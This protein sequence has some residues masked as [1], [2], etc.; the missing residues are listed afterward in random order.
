MIIYNS[1]IARLISKFIM[2]IEAITLWPFILITGPKIVDSIILRA[3][4]FY[5]IH[6]ETIHLRQWTECGL[7]GFILIY[8][9]DYLWNRIVLRKKHEDAYYDIRFEQEAYS[10]ERDILYLNYRKHYSWKKYR[11]N[12][13]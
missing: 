5:I 11:M 4:Q 12:H 2:P 10:N 6:H 7:L 1:S 3:E 9:W 8:I 13:E